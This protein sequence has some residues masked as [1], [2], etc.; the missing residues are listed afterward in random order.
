MTT[1]V[2][3]LNSIKQLIDLNGDRIN[4]ELQF[5]IDST[6][7]SP[8]D[9]LI[10]T[11][12]MLDSGQ[13]LIYQKADGSI[14]GN[15]V[16]DQGLYQNYLLLLKS[17]SP[18]EVTV[19]TQIKDLPMSQPQQQVH[20]QQQV[21]QQE[22]Q[23]QE[24][25]QQ[26]FQQQ[27]FQ[28]QR[29]QQ[30]S[31]INK[32][33][34]KINWSNIILIAIGIILLAIVCWMFYKYF[35]KDENI[36]K[37][38]L[39]TDKL[40]HDISQSLVSTIDEKL[41]NSANNLTKT[42][43]KTVDNI[44]EKID[45]KLNTLQDKF[46]NKLSSNLD[47][48]NE[49]I[50]KLPGKLSGNLNELNENI[51]KL[52]SQLSGNLSELNDNISKLPSQLSDNFSKLHEQ[53]QGDIEKNNGLISEAIGNTLNKAQLSKSTDLDSIKSQ[54]NDISVKLNNEDGQIKNPLSKSLN[55]ENLKNTIKNLKISSQL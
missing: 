40:T 39:D 18:T 54:L 19:Y 55:K 43:T 17:D 10:V 7:G 46:D 16:A 8:F 22:V 9:V 21:Q 14:G 47:E 45:G 38:I 4:F 5:K 20:Q 44:N 13:E 3:N 34:N 33:K 12:E 41:N 23:Q 51:S 32:R 15:I 50:S 36:K 26:K 48:L 2:Y 28:Q 1:T 30:H 37:E 42:L 35:T 31:P 52:P 24:V 27:Q 29:P 6:D 25:Q 53:F 11:Q 49:N